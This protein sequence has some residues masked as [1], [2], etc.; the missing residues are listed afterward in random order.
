MNNEDIVVCESVFD[1]K[2]IIDLASGHEDALVW[3]NS[4]VLRV[5]RLDC[6]RDVWTEMFRSTRAAARGLNRQAI[7]KTSHD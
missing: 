7:I 6:I 2:A 3:D 1:Q 5:E 4:R